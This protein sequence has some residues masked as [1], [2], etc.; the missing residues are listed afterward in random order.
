MK[1]T[2]ELSD[3]NVYDWGWGGVVELDELGELLL[4]L[5]IDFTLSDDE[6]G[7]DDVED[8]DAMPFILCNDEELESSDNEL[9]SWSVFN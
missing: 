2:S 7:D 5:F 1:L 6:V 4:E 3:A 9:V 8:E